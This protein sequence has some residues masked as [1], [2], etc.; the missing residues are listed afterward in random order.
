MEITEG[1]AAPPNY[2][3]TAILTLVFDDTPIL[4]TEDYYSPFVRIQNVGLDG[5]GSL[6]LSGKP[7]PEPATVL[8]VGTGL[9]GLIG[10]RKKF[11]Q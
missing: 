9:I 6:K 3:T 1:Q 7:I 11:K 8:L 2:Y 4:N 10:F 5:E